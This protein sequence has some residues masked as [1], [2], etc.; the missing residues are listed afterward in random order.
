MD[1][2]FGDCFGLALTP[3]KNTSVFLAV[4]I[5]MVSKPRIGFS[6]HS[7]QSSLSYEKGEALKNV[8]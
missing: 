3:P 5:E 6:T 8:N 4:A 7:A 1:Y 2:L